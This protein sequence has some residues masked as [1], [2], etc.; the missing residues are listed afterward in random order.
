MSIESILTSSSLSEI[1]HVGTAVDGHRDING[2][3]IEPDP[4]F[5]PVRGI[6]HPMDGEERLLVPEGLRGEEVVRFYLPTAVNVVVVGD[7]NAGT[8][9][10]Y[11]NTDYRARVRESAS[12]VRD[13]LRR[14]ASPSLDSLTAAVWHRPDRVEGRGSVG[15]PSAVRPVRPAVDRCR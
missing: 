10:R 14:R 8:I 3:W 11:D 9:V 13:R 6:A 12:T 1:L 7:D 4:V 15:D 2:E 5:A